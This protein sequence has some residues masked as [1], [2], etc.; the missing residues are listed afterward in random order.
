MEKLTLY[1]VQIV[2]TI[3]V[4][5]VLAASAEEAQQ[6]M[7]DALQ[8]RL[9]ASD[10]GDGRVEGVRCVTTHKDL[11]IEGDAVCWTKDPDLLDRTVAEVFYGIEWPIDESAP[12]IVM[13]QRKDEFQIRSE[14]ATNVWDTAQRKLGRLLGLPEWNM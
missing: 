6:I 9:V 12:D 11:P 3:S 4:E 7:A 10:G 8:A 2:G 5:P 14:R 13:E 1:A